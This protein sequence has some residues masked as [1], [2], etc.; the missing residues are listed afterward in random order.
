MPSTLT[1]A[2][3][4]CGLRFANRPLLELHIR[5][6]H[7]PRD[8]PADRDHDDSGGAQASQPG[9]GGPSRR[10][11]QASRLPRTT[12]E[13]IAMTATRR[14]RRRRPGRALTALHRAIRTLRTSTRS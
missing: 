9:A 3:S 13:V 14:P 1:P 11:N 12:N 10:Q 4:L 7:V 5:E 8:R 6:D 2:C